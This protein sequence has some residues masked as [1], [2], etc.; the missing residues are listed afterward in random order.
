MRRARWVRRGES[1]GDTGG[2]GEYCDE[3]GGKWCMNIS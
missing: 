1:S 2:Y 3:A